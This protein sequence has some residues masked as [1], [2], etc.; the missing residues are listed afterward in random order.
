M[1]ITHISISRNRVW[2]QC[3]QAYKFKYHLQIPSPIEEPGYFLYGKVMHKISEEYCKSKGETPLYEIA[4]DVL[5]GKIPLERQGANTAIKLEDQYKKSLP[6]H[7]RSFKKLISE[8][9]TDGLLEWTFKYDLDPPNGKNL[10]GFIDRIIQKGDKFFLLDYKTTKRGM[11]RKTPQ[12]ITKDLQLR[13]YARIVQK[14]FGAKPENIR[15]A[16]FYYGGG[17]LIGTKF[18]EES[19]ISAEKELLQAYNDIQG[20]DPN[21]VVGN[22]GWHCSRCEWRKLC[23]FYALT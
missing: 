5:S 23:P 12:T 15:A 8:T 9:G 1:N 18:N 11:W 3:A 17:D 7:L 22:L 14:E 4:T 13:A 10:V 19:L 16:L 6:E 2:N 21:Q 20:A